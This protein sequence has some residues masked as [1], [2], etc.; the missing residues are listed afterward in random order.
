MNKEF[1]CKGK[2]LANYL[3]ECGSTLIRCEI[4]NGEVVY[5]FKNDGAIDE[6]LDHWEVMKK[7]TMF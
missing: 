3:I 2:R 7:R 1:Q 4:D 5:V 6:R